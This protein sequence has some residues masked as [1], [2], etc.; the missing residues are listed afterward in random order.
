MKILAIDD[1]LFMLKMLQKI[2]KENLSNAEIITANTGEHGFNLYTELKPDL[3]ITDLLMPDLNGQQLIERIRE[4]D[5]NVRIIVVSADVQSST[6]QEVCKH[7]ILGF[8]NKPLIGE[9]AN[10]LIQIIKESGNA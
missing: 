4:K 1:S 7:D 3:I 5:H 9:K 2:L 6:R 8:I 10:Q